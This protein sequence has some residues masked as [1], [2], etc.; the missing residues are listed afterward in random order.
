M[1]KKTS[2]SSSVITVR[3]DLNNSNVFNSQTNPETSLTIT[4]EWVECCEVM[5]LLLVTNCFGFFVLVNR[6]IDS[7]IVDLSVYAIAIS[8]TA[9]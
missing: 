4:I 2:N 8:E 3:Y 1:C 7:T 9:V 6:V 5:L